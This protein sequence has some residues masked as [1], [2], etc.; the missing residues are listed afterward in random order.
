MAA[1]NVLDSTRIRDAVSS[2]ICK[3]GGK[4]LSRSWIFLI[5]RTHCCRRRWTLN[6]P[7][8]AHPPN[9]NGRGKLPHNALL[10]SH[11]AC[12][13]WFASPLRLAAG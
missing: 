2:S 1:M 3:K 5:E 8:R 10:F 9:A 4:A 6:S 13:T 11:I 12:R 7:F